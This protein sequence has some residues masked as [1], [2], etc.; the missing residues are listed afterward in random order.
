MFFLLSLIAYLFSAVGTFGSLLINILSSPYEVG[1]I[2]LI[3]FLVWSPNLTKLF[4]GSNTVD[5]Q[6]SSHE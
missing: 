2:L 4:K 6:E 3:A 5:H 1:L